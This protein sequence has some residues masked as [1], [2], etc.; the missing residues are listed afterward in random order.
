MTKKK[1]FA[2]T[3]ALLLAVTIPLAVLAETYDLSKGSITV[4]AKEDGQYVSQDGGVQ[5]EKQTTDTI[6]IQDKTESETTSNTITI[7]AEKD[8]TADVTL[9]GV[10]IDVSSTGS[11]IPRVS[12][13]VAI[14]TVGEGNVDIEL[15]GENT[16]KSGQDHAGLEKNNGGNLTI[17]DKDDN[18]SLVA[19][20]GVFGAGIGG[21]YGAGG[22]DI[23]ITGGSV[24]ATGGRNAAGIGG[25]WGGNGTDIT[26]TG[27]DVTAISGENA[28]GIGG[29]NRGSGSN[30]TINDGNVK[31]SS[32]WRGAG[33][34]GGQYGSG[35][36]ITINGGNVKA[37]G[38]YYGAGIGGGCSGE[39]GGGHGSDIIIAGGSVE[40]TGGKSR[41]ALNK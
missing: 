25:G 1:L 9:S 6:I 27:G 5:N 23:T 30:I 3:M 18:G 39:S 34:G 13:D 32:S 26:I 22:S 29:G 40:A 10:N 21:G 2:I 37:S 41:E 38:G 28:A 20:G 17:G 16:L 24:E 31:A 11:E 19:T 7:N 4:D 36:D 8:T 35:S 15:D 14:S 12:G 33:I